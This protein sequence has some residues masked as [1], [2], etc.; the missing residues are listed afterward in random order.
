MSKLAR[1]RS[2]P[3]KVRYDCAEGYPRQTEFHAACGPILRTVTPGGCATHTGTA[4]ASSMPVKLLCA[5][6]RAAQ[7]GHCYRSQWPGHPGQQA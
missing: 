1:A 3:R 2:S 5:W 4:L 6:A 7:G